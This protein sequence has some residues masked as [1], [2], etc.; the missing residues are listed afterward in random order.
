MLGIRLTN[1]LRASMQTS[2][3]ILLASSPRD[4]VLLDLWKAVVDVPRRLQRVAKICTRTG[5][6]HYP[7][8]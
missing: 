1:V 6:R 4:H 7:V 5:S 3:F 8:I 2:K